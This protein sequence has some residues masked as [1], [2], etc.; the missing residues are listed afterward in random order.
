MTDREEKLVQERRKQFDQ[1]FNFDRAKYHEDWLRLYRLYLG[2]FAEAVKVRGRSNVWIPMSW[3]VGEVD[4]ASDMILWFSSKYFA[5][6]FP[7]DQESVE[8][9]D[10]AEPALDVFMKRARIFFAIANAR[11]IAN[12]TGS[13]GIMPS[14]KTVT[15]EME[16]SSPMD[17]FGKKVRI[18]ERHKVE[19]S[20]YEGLEF[21]VYEP[22]NFGCWPVTAT[23]VED[24]DFIWAQDYITPRYY[25]EKV[26]EE[27][28]KEFDVSLL[29]GSAESF[30]NLNVRKLN[31]L[32]HPTPEEMKEMI[33]RVVFIWD[34]RTEV[35]LGDQWLTMEQ[36]NPL[37]RKGF[38]VGRKGFHPNSFRAEGILKP[39][40]RIQY[41]VNTIVNQI[42]IANNPPIF[43]K[44]SLDPDLI[45]F[46]HGIKIGVPNPTMDVYIPQIQGL[47]AENFNLIGLLK[48]MAQEGTG[49]TDLRMG[50]MN[51]PI[52]ATIGSLIS[53]KSDIRS[54]FDSQFWEE[55]CN[56]PLTNICIELLRKFLPDDR[57]QVQVGRDEFYEVDKAVFYARCQPYFGGSQQAMDARVRLQQFL[58]TFKLFSVF[59]FLDAPS[60][61]RVVAKQFPDIVPD[62]ELLIKQ[63][64]MVEQLTQMA[65]QSQAT[66]TPPQKQK[67]IGMAQ[68]PS[69]LMN[70]VSAMQRPQVGTAGG[71]I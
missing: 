61:F 17:V 13:A 25:L 23:C 41:A 32:G 36:Q 50:I 27:Q 64:D 24:A 15:R 69:D 55:D 39:Q 53:S 47:G 34:D 31:A 10:L 52:Q 19:K 7:Q 4:A 16:I 71:G 40:E 60:V 56:V 58:E 42:N 5:E 1:S 2:K 3:A 26:K 6:L 9:V 51:Q 12:I 33:R 22:W 21:Q 11:K 8:L 49:V 57:F 38:V 62:P 43:H 68:N 29:K 67:R 46:E 28:Y 54:R 65:G 14:Y 70:R 45:R 48:Q 63:P 66:Q 37:E 30:T 20:V 44:N 59:N 18:N 35:I